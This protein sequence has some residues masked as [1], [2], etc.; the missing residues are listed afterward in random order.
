M[1]LNSLAGEFVDASLRLLAPGGRFVEMGKTDI[2]DADRVEA[3]YP[4]RAYRAFDLLG[5]APEHIGDVLAELVALFEQGVLRHLP[6]STW[7][8][9][10]GHHAFRRLSQARHIGKLVL[11]MPPRGFDPDGT[12]LI[13]GGTGALGAAV[14]RHLVT[15]PRRP[16]AG[17]GQPPGPRRA[18]GAGRLLAELE[19]LGAEVTVAARDV[20]DRDAVAGLLVRRAPAHRRGARGRGARRR[21]GHRAD[22]GP[23]RRRAAA[24]GGRGLAPARATRDLDLAAFVLFSSAAGVLGAPGQANY[25][26]ANAFLDALAQHR[27]AQG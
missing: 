20:A 17:A 14:A 19:G 27:R 25:A 1:V 13:T 26:A 8:V 23:R 3:E 16:P 2:R 21:R 9:R 10:H 6:L 24:Q 4:G 11:T 12:V 15:R 5:V 18:R 22:P 7:D